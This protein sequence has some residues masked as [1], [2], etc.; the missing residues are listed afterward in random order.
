MTVSIVEPLSCGSRQMEIMEGDKITV[1]CTSVYGG[2]SAPTMQISEVTS[3][4]TTTVT[5][6]SN[7]TGQYMTTET[8]LIVTPEDD[9]REMVC[10]MSLDSPEYMDNCTVSLSVLCKYCCQ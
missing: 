1:F 7:V 3:D 5:K 6:G 8:S 2:E 10:H 9:E 4:M